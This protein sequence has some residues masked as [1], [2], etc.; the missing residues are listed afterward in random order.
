MGIERGWE[1]RRPDLI[2]AV[3]PAPRLTSP[4]GLLPI[5]GAPEPLHQPGMAADTLGAP[6]PTS[7]KDRGTMS[8]S[9]ESDK[10][11]SYL[12]VEQC[13]SDVGQDW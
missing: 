5:Q 12:V 7:A 4:S 8:H 2:G 9:K 6:S 11:V 13:K 3:H 1:Q 10:Q